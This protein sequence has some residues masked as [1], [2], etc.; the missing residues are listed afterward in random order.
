[1]GEACSGPFKVW[2]NDDLICALRFAGG[3]GNEVA[4]GLH[5]RLSERCWPSGVERGFFFAGWTEIVLSAR[6]EA[7]LRCLR[8]SCFVGVDA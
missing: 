7:C 5:G 4:A 2:V 8:P 6:E 1:M 3:N